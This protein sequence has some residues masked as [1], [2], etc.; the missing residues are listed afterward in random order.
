MKNHSG[1]LSRLEASAAAAELTNAE[2]AERIGYILANPRQIAPA[3]YAKIIQIIE[4]CKQ[5]R[6]AAH[7]PQ[8]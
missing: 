8:S 4:N 5:R 1:R 7:E 2:R 3:A 6:M